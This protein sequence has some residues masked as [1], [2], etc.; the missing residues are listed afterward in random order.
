MANL[1]IK[2]SADNLVLQGSDASPAITVGATGT[3]TFAE[4]ATFS[5]TANVYGQGSFPAG[6][7][8]QTTD[9]TSGTTETTINTTNNTWTDT[10]VTGSITPL[11]SNSDIAIH[12][13]YNAVLNDSTGDQGIG[14]RFK[15]TIS[16]TV[17]N[18]SDISSWESS[19]V[20]SNWY[21]NP[22]VINS[23]VDFSF[24]WLETDG[25]T[26]GTATNYTLQ[27]AQYN[28]NSCEVGGGYG[29]RW[30]IWFQEIKR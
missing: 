2:S 7:V 20:H 3:T 25:G 4:N 11:Y 29:G 15:K 18:P 27:A 6:H 16:S 8:V 1:I 30:H 14:F 22:Y 24:S 23:V 21:S 10:V 5:G 9:V 19:N 28:V 12:V 13:S 26:A 17:T